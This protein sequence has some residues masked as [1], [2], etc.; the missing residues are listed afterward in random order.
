MKF[1]HRCTSIINGLSIG[2]IQQPAPGWPDIAQPV[3]YYISVTEVRVQ[4]QFGPEFLWPFSLLL[5]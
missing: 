3:E 5:H 2:P 1:R 4:V